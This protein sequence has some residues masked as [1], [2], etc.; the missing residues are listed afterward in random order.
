MMEPSWRGRPLLWPRVATALDA[1]WRC[2]S[3]F[4]R[5]CDELWFSIRL[6]TSI[7]C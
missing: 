4:S 7:Y 3:Q 5:A 2:R 1:G 6:R